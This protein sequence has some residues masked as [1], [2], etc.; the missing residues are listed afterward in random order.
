MSLTL[1]A[2]AILTIALF[3]NAIRNFFASIMGLPGRIKSSVNWLGSDEVFNEPFVKTAVIIGI[4]CLG[5]VIGITIFEY[6]IVGI[7]ETDDLKR[8]LVIM[9]FLKSLANDI[10]ISA[11]FAYLLK[12]ITKKP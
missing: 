9:D 5:I 6:Q 3:W 7:K 11:L 8:T 1:T 4:V 2:V 10:V 12:R